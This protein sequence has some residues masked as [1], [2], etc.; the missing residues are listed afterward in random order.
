MM[1]GLFAAHRTGA[2]QTVES[3]MIVSNIYLNFEDALAYEGKPPRAAVD[4]RQFGTGATHRLYE[5]APSPGDAPRLPHGNPDPRWI[6]L[7]ADNEAARARLAATVG[8]ED[9]SDEALSATFRLRPAHEWESLL[10]D[11]GVGC[12]VA[13]ATSHFAFLY[14][15]PQARATGMMTTAE[16]PSLGGRYQRY[17][18]VLQ[19][20]ATPGIAT[21]FCE[22][23]EHSRALLAEH[24]FDDATV[25][26]LAIDGVVGIATV[27]VG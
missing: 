17:A 5:C 26:Q 18:P 3:S 21:P 1:L 24:G 7:V 15:D 27:P 2:G 16:H 4:P 20:S 22:L 13:D 19:M 23:G 10:L 9:V 14:E 11:A 6:M 25:E 12:I 8:T